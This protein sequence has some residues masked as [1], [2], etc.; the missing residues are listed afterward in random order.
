MALTRTLPPVKKIEDGSTKE[1][2]RKTSIEVAREI[3][4]TKEKQEMQSY[5]NNKITIPVKSSS[6]S[7]KKRVNFYLSKETIKIIQN[8]ANI[9]NRSMS[10][11]IELL[12]EAMNK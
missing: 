11:I 7:Q 10:E 6:K 9:S 8:H 3:S 1:V 4:E 5:K 12:V 2:T